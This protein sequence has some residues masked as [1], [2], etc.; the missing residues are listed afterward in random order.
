MFASVSNGPR[1]STR[2][3]RNN[4]GASVSGR[5]DGK[6]AS[7]D[8]I[9]GEWLEV[10][11]R[12]GSTHEGT[13]RCREAL[14][15]PRALDQSQFIRSL[16][17]EMHRG[18]FLSVLQ[19]SWEAGRRQPPKPTEGSQGTATKKRCTWS[20]VVRCSLGDCRPSSTTRERADGDDT[21]APTA[22]A[23]HPGDRGPARRGT[24][25]L[26]E[27]GLLSPGREPLSR[28]ADLSGAR[29]DE[30]RVPVTEILE[31]LHESNERVQL[32]D[33]RRYPLVLS[34]SD[35][36]QSLDQWHFFIPESLRDFDSVVGVG[37]VFDRQNPDARYFS[38]PLEDFG[39][40]NVIMFPVH[41]DQEHRYAI[42]KQYAQKKLVS[43]MSP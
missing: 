24:R 37:L 26:T 35:D 34:I 15:Q 14:G 21:S 38:I 11:A 9:A 6:H 36:Q 41:S 40:Y 42:D 31:L 18:S 16:D 27:P 30:G 7:V 17:V 25:R 3:G 33:D 2:T 28:G 12:T 39:L 4:R 20:S 19:R 22:T 10:D 29:R 32:A 43:L 13:P 8:R 23:P 5:M 1:A